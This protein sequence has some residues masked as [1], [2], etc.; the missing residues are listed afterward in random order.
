VINHWIAA[1]FTASLLII[2]PLSYAQT[3]ADSLSNNGADTLRIVDDSGLDDQVIYNAK[4]STIL[5]L[6]NNRV[7]LYGLAEV[8]YGNLTVKADFIEYRFEEQ[9]ARA[10]GKRD[11][12]G[13]VVEK[14]HFQEGDNGFDE[15]S[16]AYNFK[17]K[18][19][20]TYGVITQEGEAFLHSS[21]SKKAENNWVSIG[22][23]K[24]TTCAHPNPHFYFNLKRAMVIPNEKIV[25]GPIYPS[26]RRP[27]TRK[28]PGLMQLGAFVIKK[29]VHV[30]KIG[31]PFGFFPN[32]KEST[33]GI[34]IP[35]YG[36]ADQRGYFLQNLGYFIPL[37]QYA[38][39]K[40]LFDV[41][42]RGSWSVSNQTNYKR[43][44]KYSGSF[45]LSQNVLK[46]GFPELPS[47]YTERKTFNIQ[48]RHTQ[49]PKARPNSTFSANVNMGSTNFFRQNLNTAQ[50]DFINSTFTSSINYGKTWAG[51]PFNMG[52]TAGH[53]QNTQSNTVQVNL[54]TVA[55]NMSRI[56]LGRF[57]SSTHPAKKI[58]DLIGINAGADFANTIS[59]RANLF[60]FDA[61]DTL[62]R[63]SRSGVRLNSAMTMSLPFKK[64]GTATVTA[65]GDFTGAFRYLQQRQLSSL[66]GFEVDTVKGFL[67][68]FNWNMQANYN[69][70]LYGTFNFKNTGLLKAM[71]H[72]IQSTVG[73]G[74]TP[75][76]NFTRSYF[77]NEGNFVGYTAF[78]AAQYRPNST[79]EAFNVNFAV[80]Q[81]LEAKWRDVTQAKL[82]YKKI[83]LI[84]SWRTSMSRNML[85]DSLQWSNVAFNAF[86]TIA[87]KITVNYTSSYSLYDRDSLGREINAFLMSNNRGL[88]RMEGTNFAVGMRLRSE[89]KNKGERADADPTPAEQEVIDQNRRDLIDFS[90]PWSFNFNYNVRLEK[91]FD[92]EQLMDTLKIS[93]GITFGGDFTFLKVFAFSVQSGYDLS[94]VRWTQ[95]D[96][97]VFGLRDF[98]TTTIGL[99][100]DLHCWEFS[101]NY[102]PF[103]I[104]QSYVAQLNIKSAMLKD[105]KIQRRGNFGNLYY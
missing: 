27:D 104:R 63:L 48:W 20:I 6:M 55:F 14:A 1:F 36:N 26:F 88:W 65:N 9:V 31:L 7:L 69:F 90:V 93:Q 11:S 5:D 21:I 15:D 84:E 19:G 59:E 22:Q 46:D 102:V 34:L 32:K 3:A 38:D 29:T 18:K 75:Y 60:R 91:R 45:R 54:P 89:R 98:T 17:S 64:Y 80:N 30:P 39:T 13:K 95:F 2:S 67:P 85:A 52:V 77:D 94:K 41:Y 53:T 72:V 44:Y 96:S 61:I 71:R 62:Q 42:T 8:I 51:T 103:G 33:H 73:A 4:D 105:V 101:M 25:S 28:W 82:T 37:G 12:N 57:V 78:D 81:N 23:G 49:D 92:R 16:L 68:A 100:C 99:H 76:A 40:F 83:K 43:I 97:D 86:T 35:G 56:T 87:Q 66:N 50:D 58:L 70:R 10:I 79:A 24:F 47:S 74:Y